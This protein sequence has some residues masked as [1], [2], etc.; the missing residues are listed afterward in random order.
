MTDPTNTTTDVDAPTVELPHGAIV[1]PPDTIPFGAGPPFTVDTFDADIADVRDVQVARGTLGICVGA[2]SW[3]FDE[4]ER[5]AL[6]MLAACRA[7]RRWQAAFRS[8]AR[9]G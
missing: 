1:L 3:R 6:A 2:Y 4:A 5:L 8:A 7:G 9:E